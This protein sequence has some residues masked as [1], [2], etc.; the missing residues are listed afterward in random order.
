VSGDVPQRPEREN[1]PGGEPPGASGGWLPPSDAEPGTDPFGRPWER[2]ETSPTASGPPTPAAWPGHGSE[3]ATAPAPVASWPGAGPGRPSGDGQ[4]Q[5]MRVAEFGSR[6]QAAI[7]DFFVRL[8][9]VLAGTLVGALLFFAGET[10]GTVGLV[11]GIVIG[12]IAGLAYAPLMLART[13]GQTVGHKA[14]GTRIVN[15][16]GSTLS[17]GQ[18]AL[19]EVVVKWLVIDVVGGS[20]LLPSLLNYLWPLWDDKNEALHDKLTRTRVVEA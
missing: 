12:F 11:V 18:S 13:G 17:L 19:R 1:L 4:V 16:D 9:L 6:A 10:A 2:Q 8:A 14:S 3:Q 5:G 15:R 20:F 7:V